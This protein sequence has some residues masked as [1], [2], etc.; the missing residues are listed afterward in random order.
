MPILKF[1]ITLLVTISLLIGAAFAQTNTVTPPTV[2]IR[3]QADYLTMMNV[4]TPTEGTQNEVIA[5]INKGLNEQVSQLT[6]F[7][8][9]TVHRSL[10]NDYVVV[11]AQ[12]RDQAAVNEAVEV[13]Q[14]GGAPDML[15]AF[16]LASPEFHPYQVVSIH[17]NKEGLPE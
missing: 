4:L 11:Y 16:T 13:I 10:D 9:A 6:G 7:I 2:T 1:L 5:A 8:N 3:S 14:A 17:T 15:R 12:W